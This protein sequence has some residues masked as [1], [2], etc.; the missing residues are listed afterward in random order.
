MQLLLAKPGRHFDITKIVLLDTKNDPSWGCVQAVESRYFD[1]PG[2]AAPVLST[3]VNHRQISF[4]DRRDQ[5]LSEGWKVV[6]NTKPSRAPLFEQE[7]QP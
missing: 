5:L 2:L 4:A 1:S 3:I 7:K 6:S